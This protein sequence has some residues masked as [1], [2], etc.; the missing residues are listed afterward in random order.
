MY[1]NLSVNEIYLKIIGDKV[2]TYFQ[3]VYLACE[4]M[5]NR[6]LIVMSSDGVVCLKAEKYS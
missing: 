1:E 3:V 4:I 2:E 5:R 6:N